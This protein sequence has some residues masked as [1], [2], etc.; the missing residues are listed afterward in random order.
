MG[1]R[2]QQQ[3]T[4]VGKVFFAVDHEE[5]SLSTGVVVRRALF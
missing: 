4:K 3:G 1:R 2:V 5:V